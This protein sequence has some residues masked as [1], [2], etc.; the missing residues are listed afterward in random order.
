MTESLPDQA[1]PFPRDADYPAVMTHPPHLAAD[2]D[3]TSD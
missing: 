1:Q 3:L 2:P